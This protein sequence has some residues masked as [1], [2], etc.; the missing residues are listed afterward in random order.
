MAKQLNSGYAY[1]SSARQWR[2]SSDETWDTV[3]VSPGSERY[4]GTRMIDGSKMLVFKKG[5]K[6]YA[7]TTVS[8]GLGKHSG[9]GRSGRGLNGF[10]WAR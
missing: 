8:H 2:T 9:G 1:E 6:F 7:Q 4:V 10:G 3:M 5:K